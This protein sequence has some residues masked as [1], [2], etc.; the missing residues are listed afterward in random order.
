MRTAVRA[1]RTR[2]PAAN[3]GLVRVAGSARPVGAAAGFI[4]AATL[5]ALVALAVL[6]TYI[7]RVTAVD[8]ENARQNR[9]LLQ[10]ELD[11]RSTEATLLYLLASNRMNHRGV[12][13][14][15]EQRFT[16][17]DEGPLEATGAPELSLAGVHYAGVGD[18][19]FSLQDETGLVS[20]N[21]PR[22]PLFA[23]ALEQIGV[24]RATVSRLLPRIRDYIDLNGTLSLDGA[25]A[26]DYERARRPPPANWFL[27]TPMELERV[28]GFEGLLDADQWRRVRT[29]MTPRMLVAVNLN[30]MPVELAAAALGVDAEALAPLLAERAERPVRRLDRIVELT[31][32][33]PRIDTE[34]MIGSS[35]AYIRM[36]TWYRGG[37]RRTVV[38]ITLTPSSLIAPW[39]K[40]Y[41]YS[42]PAEKSGPLREAETG[43]LAARSDQAA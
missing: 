40:E 13:L 19:G 12:V 15:P 28:L 31:G 9:L 34:V 33:Y 3:N 4:L 6:A 8:V 36:S 23:A 17:F 10:G 16:S 37:G 11:R 39:R 24:E 29:L 5:W 30:A 25:E 2:R 43:L 27:S 18:V 22:N 14:E 41:R 20:V 1:R 35:S 42:E 38:G 7:D 26:F 32:Q 21:S